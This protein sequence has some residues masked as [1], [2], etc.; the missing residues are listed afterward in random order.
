MVQVTIFQRFFSTEDIGYGNIINL[1]SII[2]DYMVFKDTDND[3]N[4]P[5][6]MFYLAVSA[7]IFWK[8][9]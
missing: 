3:L 4:T 5:E 9:R 2:Y 8:C 7:S 6:N 1:E